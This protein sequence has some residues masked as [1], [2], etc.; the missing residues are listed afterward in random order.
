MKSPEETSQFNSPVALGELPASIK[1]NPREHTPKIQVNRL[2]SKHPIP[3]LVGKTD[4]VE[5]E[6]VEYL[7]FE[8]DGSIEL[9]VVR[10][11]PGQ[12]TLR[13]RYD[14][15]NINA[16]ARYAKQTGFAILEPGSMSTKVTIKIS[17]DDHFNVESL[18][19]VALEFDDTGTRPAVLGDL[20]YTRIVILN[21]DLF[22]AR[23]TRLNEAWPTIKA[24]IKHNYYCLPSE[25][26]WGLFWKL[27]PGACFVFSQL[28][29]KFLIKAITL[30]SSA[31]LKDGEV[32][33]IPFRIN[34]DPE[35][36]ER[37]FSLYY[38]KC[39]LIIV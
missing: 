35:A 19:D 20:R 8:A 32:R 25:T 30:S 31:Q 38:V 39:I 27:A 1:K 28:I 15:L 17:D 6:A 7:C 18:M 24:F 9:T 16:G 10:R 11:G 36:A 23:E 33:R 14:T 34:S 4:V 37:F 22:P 12:S 26:K 29:T 13:L 2:R 3:A 21:E 5:F